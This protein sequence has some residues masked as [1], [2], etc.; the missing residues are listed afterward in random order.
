MN[1]EVDAIV[2]GVGSGGTA[3]GLAEFFKEKKSDIEMVIADPEGSVV[4]DAVIS[5]HYKYEGGSWM[6]EGVE[7][8][9]YPL[10]WIF[11]YSMMPLRLKIQR[12]RHGKG[13]T[14]ERG[15]ISR[16]VQRDPHRRGN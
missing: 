16:F 4:A 5:G 1:G 14:S 3:A 11:R 9:L 2:A 13:V 15:H 8:I 6:V 12:L 10:T 7:R